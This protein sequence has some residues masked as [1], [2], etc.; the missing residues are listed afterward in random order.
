[1]LDLRATTIDKQTQK[2]SEKATE[3]QKV[4]S[5]QIKE[6]TEGM[7]NVRRNESGSWIIKSN[8]WR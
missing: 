7:K 1:M 2:L 3:L 5:K 4:L 8:S 6:W